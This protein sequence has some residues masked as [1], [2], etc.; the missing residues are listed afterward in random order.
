M[1]FPEND[2]YKKLEPELKKAYFKTLN[3]FIEIE[4]ANKACYPELSN[5]FKAFELCTFQNTSV[6]I[7]GQDPYH[8]YG[9]AN[10]LAF[11][12][13]NGQKIPPSLRNIYKELHA[14]LG[15]LPCT[16]GDLSLW[17]EQGVLLLNTTLTVEE[18]KPTSHQK[19]GW[20]EFTDSV[21]KTISE[22]KKNCVFVLWGAHA[23]SKKVLINDEC[24]LILESVHPSPL[25][26]SR[27]FFG[28]KPFS[29]VN[30][31]LEIHNKKT[32][33]WQLKS[34]GLF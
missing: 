17:A 31:Y 29:K 18:A 10:G 25:S 3:E 15:I 8:G 26:A 21:I 33:N 14:D 30:D 4:Y 5:V 23:Q 34:E 2:W 32:I 20:E 16:H 28:S 22:Q 13:N 9:Q 7:L 1:F 11:S 19:K 6:I 27:G 12:V 24:H